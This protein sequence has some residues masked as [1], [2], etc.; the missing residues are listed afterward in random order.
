MNSL[1]NCD[2]VKTYTII[3]EIIISEICERLQ[4]E[5]YIF[6]QI[7]ILIKIRRSIR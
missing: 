1:I 3:N 6:F 4:I 7:Q 5:L 2:Y